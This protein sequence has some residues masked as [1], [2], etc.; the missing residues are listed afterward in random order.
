MKIISLLMMRDEE[1]ILPTFLS[2]MQKIADEILILDTGSRDR[3]IEIAQNFGA[4]VRQGIYCSNHHNNYASWRNTLLEWGRE[5]GG[6]HFIFLDADEVFSTNY[7]TLLRKH[8]SAMH[9][10]DKLYLDWVNLWKSPHYHRT[11][12]SIWNYLWKDFVFCEDGVSQFGTGIGTHEQRTPGNTLPKQKQRVARHQ[13]VVLHYQCVPFQRFQMK[14]AFCKV[15][16]LWED[17]HLK[18]LP[19]QD[20]AIKVNRRY[21]ITLDTPS[22][23][24]K[25]IPPYWSSGLSFSESLSTASASW[26]LEAIQHFFAR[27]GTAWFEPLQLWHIP[28][29][30]Q[31]FSQDVHRVPQSL[32][33]PWYLRCKSW[34]RH[35]SLIIREYPK[36][37][38]SFSNN[39]P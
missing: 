31:I 15:R 23:I 34:L 17:V 18:H 6:S 39:S 25:P 11:D 12:W 4:H 36:R 10:G 20:S 21:A 30:L 2:Q 14:Q 24:I 5:R 22:A 38:F 26:L 27:E 8:L 7:L 19:L 9:P 37:V 3:S 35:S 1:W 33:T 32:S 29:L 28:E 13:G 16:E